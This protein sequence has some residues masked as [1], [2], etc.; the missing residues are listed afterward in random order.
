[1]I[2]RRSNKLQRIG[3]KIKKI[4]KLKDQKKNPENNAYCLGKILDPTNKKYPRDSR[5]NF[6]KIRNIQNTGRIIKNMKQK[7]SED[8]KN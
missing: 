8:K 1:M 7:D 6:W 3:R 2:R 4:R 5:K